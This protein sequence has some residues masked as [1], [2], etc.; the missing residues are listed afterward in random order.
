MR[1]HLPWLVLLVSASACQDAP[2]TLSAPDQHRTPTA[3]SYALAGSGTDL[4][5]GY[6]Y[7]CLLR[8]GAVVCYG[9]RDE[10]QPIGVHR[11]A[12][13]TIVQLSTGGTHA[14]GLRSDGAVECWGSNEFGEA[15]P[16]RQATT[17]SFTSVSAGLSHTC[18][19]RGD[20][21]VECWGSNQYGQAPETA[22]A[23][24]GTFTQVTASASSTCAL[25]T[26]G[27]VECWGFYKTAPPVQTAPSGVYVKLAPSVGATNCA[28]TSTGVA[29]CWGYLQGWHAGPYVDVVVGGNHVCAV[30][31]DGVPECW[32]YP[33]SWEGP[34]ERSA[35]TRAWS[36]ISA[37]SYHTCGLR[38][39]AY[40]ECFGVQAIGSN[41][42]DVVPVADPPLSTLQTSTWSIR[43]AWRDVNSNELRT[44]VERSV[45]DANRNPT[46]WTP[47][48]TLGANRHALVDS[49]QA[50]ATYV[51]RVRV[52]NNAGCSDWATSN[53]TAVPRTVP[54]APSS[55]AASG[56]VCGFSSCAKVT[57]TIDH[58]FVETIRLQRR[59]YNGSSY[60]A[61]QDLPEQSRSSTRFDDYGLTPGARY[62]YKVRA[63]NARGCSAYLVSYPM[64]ALKPPPPAAPATLTAS[65]M[66]PYMHL[67]WGD[68][69]NETTY[70]LQRRQYQ[71]SAWS[72]WSD[73]IV[74]TMD[75]T[76]HDDW[77]QPGT[78]S[79]YRIR[80]CNQG[81]CSAYTY[82]TPTQA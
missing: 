13:G 45:A 76:T 52:C 18:A 80:A 61:W 17:G 70:E 37:G 39:D 19:L 54:P 35:T 27:V 59:V 77:A 43:L 11:A 41:A 26:D 57:W 3:P 66:G 24:T 20:G 23:Q 6:D 81:G 78:L 1:R 31:A 9:Q 7:V 34:G 42:P 29:D 64:T 25:R 48:G 8:G 60:E 21:I 33:A 58:T 67:V 62:Q 49:V 55:V 2:P 73:P 72:A 68:V 22:A 5:S 36:R 28:L 10:S 79:Q 44:E 63:C 46:S 47:V 82:S 74:R 14:C 53:A 51:H 15:P 50:G 56:Y 32:G 4:R 69:V 12:T 30:R 65:V 40:F 71:G 16:L 38:A 75:V